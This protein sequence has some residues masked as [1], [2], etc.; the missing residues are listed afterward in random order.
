M[1]DN[2]QIMPHRGHDSVDCRTTYSSLDGCPTDCDCVC[3]SDD[4]IVWIA[5]D[6]GMRR[7]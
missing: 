5:D 3:H 1:S 7:G 4:S 6:L 2:G